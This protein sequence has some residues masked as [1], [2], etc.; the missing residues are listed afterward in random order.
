MH[1]THKRTV[2]I[3]EIVYIQKHYM[4][5]NEMQEYLNLKTFKGNERKWR[6][7]NEKNYGKIIFF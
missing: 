5:A 7:W 6:W 3:I 2:E 4:N 1:L